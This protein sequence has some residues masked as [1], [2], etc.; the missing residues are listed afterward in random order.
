MSYVCSFVYTCIFPNKEGKGLEYLYI[1]RVPQDVVYHVIV[2]Q[3]INCYYA[4][5]HSSAVSHVSHMV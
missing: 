5:A 4:K 3:C 1:K 2:L